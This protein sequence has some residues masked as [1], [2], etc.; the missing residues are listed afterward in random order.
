MEKKNAASNI[1]KGLV[2]GSAMLIPGVS[3]GTTAIILDVYDDL[4]SSI[5]SF[6][7]ETKK[8]LYTLITVG[9][10]AVLGILLFSRAILY[11]TNKFYV[12]MMFLFLGAVLGSVPMLYK[13]ADIKKFNAG[14][15]IYPL[16]GAACV[17]LL[18]LIPKDS[19]KIPVGAGF[20]SYLIVILAGIVLSIGLVLPGISVSY[21]L[22]I[23]GIYE[24]TLS[25]IENMQYMFLLSLLF[26]VALGVVLTTKL[27]EYTMKMYPSQTYLLIIGFVLASLKEVFPGIPY[28]MDI[29][30]SLITLIAG[31]S[32]VFYLSKISD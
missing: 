10:G 2:I 14:L 24:T 32:A 23:L 22:L 16:I 18:E 4:I 30:S 31:F 17:Y 20:Y 8:S 1:L 29:V 11:V 19:L 6:F 21:M 3:G 27:L 25:S 15:I 28:G 5:S 13:K 26:G 7:K 9:I 12:P